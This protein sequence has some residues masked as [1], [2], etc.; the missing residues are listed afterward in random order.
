MTAATGRLPKGVVALVVAAAVIMASIST[1]AIAA[2]S[3]GLEDHNGAFGAVTCNAP[4]LPG[5][6]INV[7]E[8]DMGSSMMGGGLMR[9][10][11]YANPTTTPAG[12]VSFVVRNEGNLVH[13]MLV[14]PLPADGAGT[15]AT[16]SDG[17][18]NEA[19]SLGEAS[20]SCA[21]GRGD[22]IAPGATSWVTLDLAPGRYELVC[23]QPWHY[24]AGMFDV[25][26]V[27]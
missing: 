1:V 3:G 27:Q 8:A 9:P 7:T 4:S 25:L 23:D 20:R 5:A 6:T 12:K 24:A 18:I 15:R 14:M 17:K 26:T 11:L 2:L 16:G 13:E 10:S 21:T 22:G 19:A